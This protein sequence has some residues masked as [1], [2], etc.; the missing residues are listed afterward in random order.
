MLTINYNSQ[1]PAISDFEAREYAERVCEDYLQ[2]RK[3]T[4]IEVSTEVVMM[5][6]E[7]MMEKQVVPVKELDFRY[8]NAPLEFNIY[9]G[10]V[11]LPRDATCYDIVDDIFN[12]MLEI[13]KSEYFSDDTEK[14]KLRVNFCPRGEAVS[15]AAASEHIKQM[16]QNPTVDKD[17]ILR[18]NFSTER[19]LDELTLMVL[20]GKINQKRIEFY[21]CDEKCCFDIKKGGLFLPNEEG[22][23]RLM[24]QRDVFDAGIKNIRNRKGVG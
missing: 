14:I 20:N 15:D 1:A 5:A 4:I 9:N 22:T 11:N 3:D 8:N 19:V 16:L 24:L 10:I 12:K 17:N 13:L 2:S 21:I 23:P 7:L 18:F 6:F